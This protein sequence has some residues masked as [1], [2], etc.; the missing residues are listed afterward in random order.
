MANWI[1]RLDLKDLWDKHSQGNLTVEQVAKETAKRIRALS[2]YK[3]YEE[4]LEE[5][6]I[7]FEYCDN[8]T[9]EFDGILERLYD[10]ADGCLPTSEREM[11]KKICWIKTF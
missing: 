9:D 10:W 6:A 3:K 8:D 7:D 2:C 1:Y 11:Q 4:E 5:I